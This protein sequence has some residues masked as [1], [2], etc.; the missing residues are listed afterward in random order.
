MWT[1]ATCLNIV[2]QIFG[3]YVLHDE[4]TEQLSRDVEQLE[5]ALNAR[6]RELLELN[7]ELERRAVLIRD[8]TARWER[9]P[10]SVSPPA[11]SE[12]HVARLAKLEA[13]RDAAVARALDAEAAALEARFQID[14]LA[15][16]LTE[17]RPDPKVM[18]DQ[19][20]VHEG[21][22]RGL[23][24]RLAEAEDARYRAEARLMLT[25][26]DLDDARNEADALRRQRLELG[27]RLE[28][29]ALRARTAETDWAR[30]RGELMG[31]RDRADESER[32]VLALR[33][34]GVAAKMRVEDLQARVSLS[35]AEREAARGAIQHARAE[36][37]AALTEVPE[38][39]AQLAALR[40]ELSEREADLAA[41]K[42]SHGDA[43]EAGD[44][45]SKLQE[46]LL[47]ARQGLRELSAW[48]G[49]EGTQGAWAS[50]TSFE[51]EAPVGVSS[52]PPREDET[53]PGVP[54]HV[55]AIAAVENMAV[56]AL[57]EQLA[58]K[59]EQLRALEARVDELLRR[60]GS[61]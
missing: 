24:S 13:E 57:E 42:A 59:D 50:T 41:M 29:E 21:A 30:V 26:H 9:N 39:R 56:E 61:I 49:G 15:G 54:L 4:D 37:D 48:L 22:L 34:D 32:A 18:A 46:A 11:Q 6:A 27:E 20:A 25:E 55:Q 7:A 60:H 43:S 35:L 14:E 36:R 47:D 12:P 10:A 31:T 28:M 17:A 23:R 53:L 40:D 2:A 58:Q 1:P 51:L 33:A 8:L 19:L 3:G 38:L 52:R 5:A 45:A 16:H 44:R